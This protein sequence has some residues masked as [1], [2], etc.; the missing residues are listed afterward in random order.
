MPHIE[1]A[2]YV[3]FCHRR[4]LLYESL[5]HYTDGIVV[6]FGGFEQEGVPFRQE[7]SFYYLT[8]IKEPGVVFAYD[9]QTKKS[10]LYVPRYTTNRAIWVEDV[11]SIET[12]P[13]HIGVD[14][15]QFLGDL[16]P[17][18]QCHPFFSPEQ[19]SEL[20]KYL[21]GH[22]KHRRQLLTLSPTVSARYVE[23][24]FMLDSLSHIIE[25][26]H[27]QIVDIA[28]QLA[29]LRRKKTKFEL[30]RMYKAISITSEAFFSVAPSI[31]AGM[32]EYELQALIEYVFTSL[33][34]TTAFASIVASGRN[35]T[36]LHYQ[37]NNKKIEKGDLVVIDI[38]CEYAYYCADLTRTFPVSHTFSKRQ[39]EIYQH[40]LDVQEE[41]A[42]YAQPGY[43]L[44][45][46]HNPDKSLHHIAVELF[47]QKGLEQ[48]F[49][50]GIGHF[51]GLDVHDVGDYQEPLQQDDVITI[52]PG[53]YIPQEHLGVRIEDNYWIVK[54]G[55]VSLSEE[56]PKNPSE[57]VSM[58]KHSAM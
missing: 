5:A 7:S 3:T 26:F 37:T 55:C 6:L 53:I 8:G 34:G 50:H 48:F 18:Y 20:I 39:E 12:D 9:M 38:G 32:Y 11:I 56:L 19:Y 54:D 44:S 2:D 47:K 24:R 4:S 40:V 31:E 28:P 49:V 41:V 25:S 35:S 13:A 57:L 22:V 14:E 17:G 23:Q 45:N 29:Q 27:Q 42:R 52:E 1:L 21:S 15:I 43:W 33:G 10:V 16:C 30:E 46:K 36:T 51:L 58:M